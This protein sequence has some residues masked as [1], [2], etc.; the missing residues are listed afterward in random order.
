MIREHEGVGIKKIAEVL[1]VSSSAATQLVDE[2]ER[3]KFVTRKTSKEDKRVLHISLSKKAQTEL[4]RMTQVRVEAFAKFFEALDDAEFSHY[5]M[6][7]KKI[8]SRIQSL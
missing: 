6:L 7:N 2:L 5:V 3:N 8:I 1:G 4:Q